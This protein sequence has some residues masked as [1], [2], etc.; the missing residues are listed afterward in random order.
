LGI[1]Q[2]QMTMNRIIAA[3]GLVLFL[4]NPALA[5]GDVPAAGNSLQPSAT[6]ASNGASTRV[7]APGTRP[8]T[9]GIPSGWSARVKDTFF[10]D[11]SGPTLRSHDEIRQRWAALGSQEQ[12]QVRADCQTAEQR[13]VDNSAVKPAPS[14]GTGSDPRTNTTGGGPGGSSAGLEAGTTASTNTSGSSGYTPSSSMRMASL[15]Q[16]CQIVNGM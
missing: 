13:I 3:A 11:A 10:S 14:D 16:V 9:A 5:Q 2:E 8:T 15:K 4:D 1:G 7:G 6:G 12:A